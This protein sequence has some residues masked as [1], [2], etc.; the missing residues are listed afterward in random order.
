[1]NY[2]DVEILILGKILSD[3][4]LNHSRLEEGEKRHQIRI[5]EECLIVN[6]ERLNYEIE[7][8]IYRQ[9]CGLLIE[10]YPHYTDVIGD[11]VHNTLNQRITNETAVD[12]VG[13]HCAIVKQWISQN[14]R[15]VIRGY[16]IMSDNFRGSI[17]STGGQW[18]VAIRFNKK[19]WEYF[20]SRLHTGE[21]GLFPYFCDLFLK[22]KIEQEKPQ[23]NVQS[24]LEKALP[25][26]HP[27]L[28]FDLGA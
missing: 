17:F 23:E 11:V 13:T 28:S 18:L 7:L 6:G 3:L 20:A 27:L 16:Q 14:G 9:I 1:M 4:K 10:S 12:T 25:D 8:S 26:W 22:G 21:I 19:P 5:L 2:K 15:I 24:V